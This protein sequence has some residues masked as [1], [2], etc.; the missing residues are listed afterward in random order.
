MDAAKARV[1]ED[2]FKSTFLE[3]SKSSGNFERQIDD[4]PGI[5]D[6]MKLCREDLCRP[7]R[8]MVDAG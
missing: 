1:A 2:L 5:F 3:D 4:P 7:C 6:G 8:A